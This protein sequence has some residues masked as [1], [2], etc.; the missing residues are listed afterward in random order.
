MCC[1]FMCEGGIVRVVFEMGVAEA[2][3]VAECVIEIADGQVFGRWML[4]VQN[5]RREQYS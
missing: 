2:L 3:V 4:D 1:V 5:V